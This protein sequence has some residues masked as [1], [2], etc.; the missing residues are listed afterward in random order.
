M[1]GL[2]CLVTVAKLYSQLFYVFRLK[3]SPSMFGYTVCTLWQTW[4]MIDSVSVV[5]RS[6][7]Y[8]PVNPLDHK[9]HLL[10][11]ASCSFELLG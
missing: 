9:C 1:T 7:M 3:Y 10:A 6:H 2:L 5:R 11:K 4:Q 8:K